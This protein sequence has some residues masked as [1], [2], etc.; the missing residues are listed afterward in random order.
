MEAPD[1]TC[2]WARTGF[3]ARPV[4][5][6]RSGSTYW[7]GSVVTSDPVQLQLGVTGADQ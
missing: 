1:R 3:Q 2:Q 4:S 6:L 5:S 7:F